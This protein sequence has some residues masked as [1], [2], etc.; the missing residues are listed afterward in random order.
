MKKL[1]D[2]RVNELFDLNAYVSYVKADIGQM[3]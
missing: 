2:S 1:I 3:T